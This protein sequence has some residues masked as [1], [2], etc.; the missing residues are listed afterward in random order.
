MFLGIEIGGTKQQVGLGAGGG[1]LVSL[2]N[3]ENL[4]KRTVEP[5]VGAA[6]IRAK[7]E[8]MLP[9]L[10]E[11]SGI[12]PSAVKG[13]G[14]GFGGPFDD[15][16]GRT[17]KSHHIDG[18]DGFPLGEW[19]K[20]LLNVPVAIGNDADVAGLGEALFG[21]GRGVSPLFYITVGTGIGGGLILDG[22]IYRA[23]GRGA[24]EIGHL[25]VL[26]WS[27]AGTPM[28]IEL[29]KIASG[30]AIGERAK[31]LA[32]AGE[33]AGSLLLELVEGDASKITGTLV[34]RAAKKKDKF[35]RNVLKEATDALAEAICQM[36]AL[37]CPR[38]IVIGGGVASNGDE[39]FFDPLRAA[40]AERVFR[41]FA[42]LTDIVPAKLAEEVVIH[43]AIGLA[44]RR[45][46]G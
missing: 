30:F 11:R 42:D 41:P 8:A 17:I 2:G 24:A 25:K 36:I 28:M 19:A 3:E 14:I 46:N 35:S 38:R 13:I 31:E 29:E 12:S 18:W 44:A 4:L 39:L 10:W 27:R 40:V 33:A 6:G 43:G 15:A 1:S 20:S 23:V 26:D 34:G 16:T 37:V 32:I 21:A 5:S 9:E 7:I 45:A 22:A